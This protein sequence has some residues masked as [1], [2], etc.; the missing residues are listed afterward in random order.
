[1]SKGKKI[2]L[3]LLTVFV[4]ALAVVG[5]WAYRTASVAVGTKDHPA[6]FIE[7]IVKGHEVAVNPREGFPGQDK[8]N[9]LC[10]GIDDNWTDRDIVYTRGARTDTLFLLT[11]DLANG[12]ASMLSIPRDTYCHIAGTRDR[13]FK[14]NE[15]YSTG[16]PLRSIATVDELL[17][18]H[19]DHYLVLNIDA[20][21][22][23][24]DALGGVDLNVEHEM[25]YHDKWGHLS[26]DLHPGFQHLDGDQAVGF[27]RY[28]H[29]D[30]GKRPTPEDGDERRMYRQHVLLRAMIAKAKTFGAIS[31]SS[32]LFQTAMST[33][34]TDL[35]QTQLLDLAS[36]YHD[37][38]PDA[39]RT[40]SLPGD[41]FRGPSGEWF[42][43]L[44]PAEMRAYVDWLVRDDPAPIEHL[45]PIIVKN[46]TS[47]PGLAQDAVR[48]LKAQGYTDVHNGGNAPRPKVQLAAATGPQKPTLLHTVILDT[49]V[50]DPQT[51]AAVA[52]ELGVSATVA[53][54]PLK[55]NKVG[56]TPPAAV[57]ISL[58]QDYANAVKA[59]APPI[60][61]D[62]TSNG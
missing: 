23:M 61:A 27:A 1:M 36:L 44:Y 34:R 20:T 49:G 2:A 10:M 55:P 37:I 62:G 38:Q 41:D 31:N 12:R 52:Q 11:L 33:I 39:I 14:I 42:Y 50:P 15:A 47:A 60:T 13:Y 7:T 51:P 16:G 24:V 30:A 6:G 4:F 46:G 9:I 48:L 5:G 19:A 25:H 53:R 57:T 3:G 22:K 26:I 28:R 18:V 45:T 59:A 54:H 56:W 17:G 40:A 32:S 43:K 29:P 58:G 35:T 21:K 8:I